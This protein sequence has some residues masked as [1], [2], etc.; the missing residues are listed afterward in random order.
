MGAR[1]SKSHLSQ[2]FSVALG[3]LKLEGVDFT[4]YCLAGSV[5]HSSGVLIAWNDSSV[6]LQSS[7]HFKIVFDPWSVSMVGA[8][9]MWSGK[10][11]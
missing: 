1:L 10:V 11:R 6:F 3:H 2:G 8:E 7:A 4:P 5:T 9:S